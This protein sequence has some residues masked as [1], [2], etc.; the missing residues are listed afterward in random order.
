MMI[1]IMSFWP[2]IYEKIIAQKKLIEYR[3]TFP[4]DCDYAYMYVSKPV[5][6]ICAIIYF[7]KK[8]AL[9]DW[10]TEYASNIEVT[11]RILDY[12]QNYRYGA[13]IIGIQKIQPI[14]LKELRDNVTNFVAPQSYVLL[15]NNELLSNYVKSNTIIID[16][17]I[18][19]NLNDIFPE[20]I[21]KKV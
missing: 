2:C 6:A 20:H 3:R 17:K 21:C 19:N 8:H 11:K 7:G 4:K 16:D 5:K 9:E 12:S 14:T 18:I 10:K 1:P 13:E 15:E